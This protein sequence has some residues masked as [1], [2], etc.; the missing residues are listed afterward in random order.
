MR[1]MQRLLIALFIIATTTAQA[2]PDRAQLLVQVAEIRAT[3]TRL[4]EQ[5]TVLE[6]LLGAPLAAVEAQAPVAQP[7]PAQAQ[8]AQWPATPRPKI[9]S[10][11]ARQQCVAT[12]RRGTRCLGMSA[13]RSAY[14]C[15]HAQ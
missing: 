12:S 5:L 13:A 2:Q 4:Q 1:H 9:Q 10:P 7:L 11:A 6:K 14:C 15:Q 8:A 3:V